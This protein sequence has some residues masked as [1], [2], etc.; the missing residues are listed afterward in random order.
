MSSRETTELALAH[1]A[2]EYP[3]SRLSAKFEPF[4]QLAM[5]TSTEGHISAVAHGKLEIIAAQIRALQETAHDIIKQAED[6]MRLHRV[7]CRFEKRLGHTYHLYDR[8]GGE[9]FSMLSPADWG[10]PPH[11]FVGSYKLNADMTWTKL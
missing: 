4:N 6:N 9:Y 10:T 2:S 5:L 7:V 8:D 3:I 1:N 11:V